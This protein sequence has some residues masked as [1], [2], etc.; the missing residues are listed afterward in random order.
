MI[1]R[2]WLWP[3]LGDVVTSVRN[4]PN[5]ATDSRRV[6]ASMTLP[7]CPKWPAVALVQ[8]FKLPLTVLVTKAQTKNS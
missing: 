2:N 1:P 6:K 5:R 4:A 7:L 3:S 8:S